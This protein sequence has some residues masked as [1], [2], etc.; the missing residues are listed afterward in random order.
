MVFLWTIG[1][2][3]SSIAKGKSLLWQNDPHFA[4]RVCIN[5]PAA[6]FLELLNYSYEGK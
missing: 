2:T 3:V 4:Y 6:L 5:I 1:T